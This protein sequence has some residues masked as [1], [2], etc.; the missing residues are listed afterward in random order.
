MARISL[1]LL[2]V[3]AAGGASW[4]MLGPD[5]SM[6][7]ASR[8]ENA[9]SGILKA[10]REEHSAISTQQ[11]AFTIPAAAEDY[12]TARAAHRRDGRPLVVLVGADWCAPCQVVKRESLAGL[13]RLG[14]FSYVDADKEP[15]QM[16]AVCGSRSPPIPQVV[17]YRP[18]QAVI[19]RIGPAA[20]AEL[21]REGI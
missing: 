2:C 9:E 18:G 3:F 6:L 17:V 12:A 21:V 11:S 14:H 16:A 1:I 20:I 13:K 8:S 4:Q 19:R 7:G 5:W 15:R 10:E